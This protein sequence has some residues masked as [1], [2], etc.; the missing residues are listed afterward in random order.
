M[1]EADISSNDNWTPS[2]E[3]LARRLYFTPLSRHLHRSKNPA[4]A[5][6]VL[7]EDSQKINRFLSPARTWRKKITE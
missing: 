6:Q 1:V 2:S 5:C 3:E 4:K 7:T